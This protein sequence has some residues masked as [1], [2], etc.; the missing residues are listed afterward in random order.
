MRECR[1]LGM[2]CW[3]CGRRVFVDLVL[4]II[5]QMPAVYLSEILRR[6]LNV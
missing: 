1:I 2:K 4:E 5:G 3:R 6:N